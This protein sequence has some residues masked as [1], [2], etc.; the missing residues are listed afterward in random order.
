MVGA[1]LGLLEITVVTLGAC[2]PK[3]S[4]LTASFQTIFEFPEYLLP[5]SFSCMV[6][7]RLGMLEVRVVRLGALPPKGNSLGN[8]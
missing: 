3:G 6:D 2:L 4:E 1:R 7:A 8:P 5:V